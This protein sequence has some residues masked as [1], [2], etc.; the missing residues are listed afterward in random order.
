MDKAA[1]KGYDFSDDILPPN[2]VLSQ[3]SAHDSRMESLQPEMSLAKSSY[4]TRFWRYIEGQERF[5]AQQN[6]ELSRL[7]QIEVNKVK[8]AIS[9]YLNA[10]YPRRINVVVTNSPYTKGDPKKAEMLLT[11]WVNKPMMRERILNCSRQAL[12]YKGSGAKIGYDPAGEGLDRVWMR[13]FPYWE[14]VLD[15]DV[16]DREDQR[17]VGH[18]SYRPKQQVIDEYGLEP[19]IAGTKRNDYLSSHLSGVHTNSRDSGE[20]AEDMQAFVRV[21]EFCNLVD[22]F[23]DMDGNEYKGRLEIYVLGYGEGAEPLPVYMGPLPLVDH[24]GHPMS[25]IVPLLFEHEPEYP[26]RGL[27]YVDQLMPQQKEINALRSFTSVAARR[28]ARVYLA[29]KGSLDADAYS[30]L[31]SGEDGLIIEVDEQYA[32]NLRDVVVPIQHG[33]LSANLLESMRLAEMDIDRQVTV[34]PAALG[35]IT[36]ATA[37][38]IR[39]VERH[40]DSEFGRHAEQRDLWLLEILRRC[41]SAHVASMYDTGDSE[42]AEQH[43]DTEGNELTEGELENKR[44]NEGIEEDNEK[45]E[46]ENFQPHKMFDPDS[47]KEEEAET[48]EEH[49]RLSEQGYEHGE[50]TRLDEDGQI[51]E[52]EEIE[53]TEPERVEAEMKP[54]KERTI[55]LR[56]SQGELLEVLPED[57]DSDFDIGFAESGRS[58][59]ADADTK[60]NI[61]ALMDRI[62]QLNDVAFKGGPMGVVAKELLRVLHDRFNFPPNL[63]PDYIDTQV[64]NLEEQPQPAAG[65][66]PQQLEQI[67]QKLSQMPPEQALNELKEI[68]AENPQLVQVIDQSLMSGDPN[69]QAETVQMILAEIRNQ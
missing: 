66:Q 28:D 20:S 3:L 69:D 52:D 18:V 64:E 43:V 27:S 14:M 41:L 25:H 56:T 2:E 23:H 22:K 55:M 54:K 65:E 49:I 63:H 34:S 10:L 35:Q 13:V 68:F 47:D 67:V 30:D 61:V 21:L 44:D 19:E 42:G 9:G 17:F 36:K 53:E 59:Q 51:H 48:Y 7:D 46:K 11:D 57:L 32:G 6:Y 39:A 15:H 8:P 58:P 5:N 40:T 50:R 26:L 1:I 45:E 33:T 29:R 62:L 16:H 37:E 12:L 60:A 24:N 4:M 31:K 38:E